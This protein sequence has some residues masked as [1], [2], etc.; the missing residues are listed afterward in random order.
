M[1]V[2]LFNKSTSKGTKM[3]HIKGVKD[4]EHKKPKVCFIKRI[5]VSRG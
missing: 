1:L 4:G 2:I 5:N 3:I